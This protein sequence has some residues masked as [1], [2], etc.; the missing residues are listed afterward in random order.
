MAVSK[1]QVQFVVGDYVKVTPN[2]EGSNDW[3]GIVSK[4]LKNG[5]YVR[6]YMAATVT[7]PYPVEV[8]VKKSDMTI[9]NK[10][11]WLKVMNRFADWAYHLVRQHLGSMDDAE[12][13]FLPQS[14]LDVIGWEY[15]KVNC[16]VEL[17]ESSNPCESVA[18]D[19]LP[20]I[21]TVDGINPWSNEIASNIPESVVLLC[22][23]DATIYALKQHTIESA[24]ASL[25]CTLVQYVLNGGASPFAHRKLAQDADKVIKAVAWMYGDSSRTVLATWLN[26]AVEIVDQNK[27]HIVRFFGECKGTTTLAQKL[28]IYLDLKMGIT[29]QKECIRKA[30]L[31]DG[32]G[33]HLVRMWK[34]GTVD[35][36]DTYST[37]QLA[38]R[39]LTNMYVGKSVFGV[40]HSSVVLE[41]V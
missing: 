23:K 27:G 9:I 38:L 10:D 35:V 14:V 39:D 6:N 8:R 21:Q 37:A 29:D 33:F 22:S 26:D 34:N 4:V 7:N 24:K 18:T 13:M 41:V 3:A 16:E 12:N 1:K 28:S 5:V 2:V 17:S 31:F 36:V 25:V 15:P 19:E 32:K 20:A 40:V 11:E 30:E